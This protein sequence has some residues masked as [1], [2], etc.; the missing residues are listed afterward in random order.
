MGNTMFI[1][2]RIILSRRLNLIDS[3]INRIAKTTKSYNVSM[4]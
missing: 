1:M 4:N 3:K 2:L